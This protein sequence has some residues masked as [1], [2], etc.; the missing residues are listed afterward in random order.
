M[1][2]MVDPLA[3]AAV[4]VNLIFEYPFNRMFQA[5]IVASVLTRSLVTDTL[6]TTEVGTF[7]VIFL[8]AFDP[9]CVP[10][11]LYDLSVQVMD[12]LVALGI[13]CCQLVGNV[14]LTDVPTLVY[15]SVCE[16]SVNVTVWWSAYAA[17]LILNV[18]DVDP[19]SCTEDGVVPHVLFAIIQTALKLIL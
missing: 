8:V 7:P 10:L 5:E 14:T 17:L 13:C 9:I 6:G 3:P 1:V 19:F 15:V 2:D 18:Y 4:A 12:P 11:E 16:P